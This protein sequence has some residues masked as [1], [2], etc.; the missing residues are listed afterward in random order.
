MILRNFS[1]KGGV[2]L[3]FSYFW[4]FQ[5]P[6]AAPGIS[7]VWSR[8]P[9]WNLPSKERPMAF[10]ITWKNWANITFLHLTGRQLK[11]FSNEQFQTPQYRQSGL[12]TCSHTGILV[13][14]NESKVKTRNSIR[15]PLMTMVKSSGE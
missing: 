7:C 12:R 10:Y 11:N 5:L 6:L 3:T 14:K 2:S 8:R 9:P 13:N 1:T 15:G 4:F